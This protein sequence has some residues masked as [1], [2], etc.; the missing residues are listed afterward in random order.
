MT[1]FTTFALS[2]SLDYIFLLGGELGNYQKK[3][4]CKAN[5]AMQTWEQMKNLGGL[6]AGKIPFR[7]RQRGECLS[8]W[9]KYSLGNKKQRLVGDLF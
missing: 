1:Q 3:M 7:E 5:E 2:F 9:T 8:F 6:D 4:S